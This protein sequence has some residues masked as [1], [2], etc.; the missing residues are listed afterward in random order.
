MLKLSYTFNIAF[1]YVCKMWMVCLSFVCQD[2]RP[3]WTLNLA[4]AFSI[5]STPWGQ[6]INV[7]MPDSFT[8]F[9]CPLLISAL[10]LVCCINMNM[11]HS[12]LF[13]QWN[14]MLS[15]KQSDLDLMSTDVFTRFSQLILDLLSFSKD[16]ISGF[17]RTRVYPSFYGTL[18]NS[19]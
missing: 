12:L 15:G 16:Y 6:V 13:S 10:T 19:T 7:W 11:A 8:S 5:D 1:K 9:C 2:M 14:L 4:C 17:S 18:A 3:F